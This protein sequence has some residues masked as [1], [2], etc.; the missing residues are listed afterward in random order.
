MLQPVY[1]SVVRSCI[2]FSLGNGEGRDR[3]S[4]DLAS[5]ATNY[6]ETTEYHHLVNLKIK[7]VIENQVTSPLTRV[8][9]SSNCIGE[10]ELIN[11]DR[12]CYISNRRILLTY[13][14]K[15]DQQE[16]DKW[17]RKLLSLKSIN[18]CQ[19]IYKA[20][21]IFNIIV[22]C[23]ATAWSIILTYVLRYRSRK[24]LTWILESNLLI[25]KSLSL[26]MFD[27]EDFNWSIELTKWF[28]I[29]HV[30]SEPKHVDEDDEIPVLIRSAGYDIVIITDNLPLYI[31]KCSRKADL[32]DYWECVTNNSVRIL[33]WLL[34][35]QQFVINDLVL[36]INLVG[37]VYNNL[38]KKML[39]EY[40]QGGTLPRLIEWEEDYTL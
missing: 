3:H 12:P 10:L 35:T 11:R 15:I 39:I 8:K 9:K 20:L 38:A 32:R 34:N 37:E 7:S 13:G 26:G 16:Y 29:V 17:I 25:L 28:G 30:P 40:V 19:H 2:Y 18:V 24:V 21:D 33:A 36:S 5:K 1:R 27:E 6:V 4:Y 14:T 31:A 22:K 23:E